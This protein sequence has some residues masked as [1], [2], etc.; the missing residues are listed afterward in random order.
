MDQACQGGVTLF[1]R[2][3]SKY[4][5]H[6]RILV[7]NDDG[8]DSPGVHVLAQRLTEI[9]EVVV[10]APSGEYSGAGA[11]IGHL[12]GGIPNVHRVERS[13]MPD[14]HETHHLDGPPALAALLGCSGLLGPAPDLVVS[15]I[16]PGWNVGHAVHFSGTVGAC[17]T[18]GI[19]GV[20]AIAVSQRTSD[21]P[22][23]WD[24]AAQA[25]IDHVPRALSEGVLLN[26]NVP[27]LS[28]DDIKGVQETGLSNRIPYSLHSPALHEIANGEFRVS[29][30]QYGPFD[31]P[32]GTDTHAVE[33]GYVSVTPLTTTHA[34]GTQ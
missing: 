4:R 7:T 9:G 18:A 20:P 6:V 19:F 24:T 33:A 23:L 30:E 11:A 25:A 5:C 16:N 27:N 26:I 1:P 13:E 22:M 34:A 12:A 3:S 29:F 8:I 32:E 2:A 15:G 14:V 17:I 28:V 21:E 31:G 10:F